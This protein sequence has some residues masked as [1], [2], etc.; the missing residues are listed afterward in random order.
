MAAPSVKLRPCFEPFAPA[1]NVSVAAIN[2][3]AWSGGE[4]CLG[5]LGCVAL[6][7]G[8][9]FKRKQV[10]FP[11]NLVN[12]QIGIQEAGQRIIGIPNRGLG[13]NEWTGAN[14]WSAV[15][16]RPL[17]DGVRGGPPV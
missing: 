10:W 4:S 2:Q 13:F 1:P 17:V 5:Q 6:G 12:R 16:L 9:S 14:D 11:G 8:R 15:A 7:L 3:K